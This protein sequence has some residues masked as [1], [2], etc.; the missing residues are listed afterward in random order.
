LVKECYVHG[1]LTKVLAVIQ[2]VSFIGTVD[3]SSTMH[4]LVIGWECNIRAKITLFILCSLF[5]HPFLST[6]IKS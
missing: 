2:E 4:A 5:L 1:M 6:I 3:D